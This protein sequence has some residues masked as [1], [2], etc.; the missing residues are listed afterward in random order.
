MLTHAVEKSLKMA[1][2][3]RGETNELMLLSTLC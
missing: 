1:I 3:K 2:I